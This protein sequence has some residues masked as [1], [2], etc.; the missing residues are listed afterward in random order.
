LV[1]WDSLF[2]LIGEVLRGRFD[3]LTVRWDFG[4]SSI[5]VVVC[6]CFE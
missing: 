4:W 3:P 6:S 2:N 5:A 1:T